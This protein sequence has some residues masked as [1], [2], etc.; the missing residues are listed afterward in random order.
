MP[1]VTIKVVEQSVATHDRTIVQRL[2]DKLGQVFG[3]EPQGTWVKLE[4]LP[5]SQYA[6]NDAEDAQMQPT[7]VE[8]LKKTL[9]SED[10]L[11]REALVVSEVVATTLHRSQENCHVI[12]A[13]PGEG[14]VAFG[15]RLIRSN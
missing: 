14:R 4:Y 11:A 7:F 5:R 15:G 1:I 3:S 9:S 6:E 2:A 10:V 8:I 13:P 12:Y